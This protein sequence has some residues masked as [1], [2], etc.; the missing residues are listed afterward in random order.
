M[1]VSLKLML[2]A[3]IILMGYNISEFIASYQTVCEKTDEFMKLARE[4]DA[5]ERNLRFSNLLISV[6]LSVVY[7]CLTYFSGLAVW[8]TVF[9]ALKLSFTLFCSDSMLV[10]V[11]RTK[12]V[13]KKIYLI[14]KM[15][16]LINAMI[17]LMIALALVM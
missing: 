2:I 12:V 4:T 7:I 16:A 15:D 9:V 10:R 8:L 6:V 3:S 1:D 14:S 17:G 5:D 11:L 13:S